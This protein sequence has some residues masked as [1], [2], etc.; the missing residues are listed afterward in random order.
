MADAG[1]GSRGWWEARYRAGDT[2]WNSGIVPPEIERLAEALPVRQGWALDLGC[3]SGVTSLFLARHGF[4]VIGV[5]VAIQPLR[6]A[7]SRARDERQQAHFCCA[8]GS[9]LGFLRPLGALLAVDVGCLHG[10][11]PEQRDGYVRSLARHVAQRGR[12]LLYAFSRPREES[13]DAPGL[14][15]QDVA[16]LAPFFVL[17]ATEHGSYGMRPSAWYLFQRTAREIPPFPNPAPQAPRG[18][19]R[20]V[21]AQ[22]GRDRSE[23]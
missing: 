4:R 7:R 12:F 6:I 22:T 1:E 9:D 11:K 15:P 16:A 18:S 13:E 5:D 8:D 19:A 2:P 23:M 17:M 10:L 3:G 21:V 20:V 14:R